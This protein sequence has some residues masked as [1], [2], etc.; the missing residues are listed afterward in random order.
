MQWV[1]AIGR[2]GTALALGLVVACGDNLRVTADASVDAPST[3][4]CTPT[5]GTDLGVQL[6][7]QMSGTI[8]LVT[9]PP[10]DRD[11][12]FAVIEDGR[13]LVIDRGPTLDDRGSVLAAPFLDISE[14][15]GDLP[16]L[17]YN[18]SE[19]GLLGLA[20]HPQYATNGQLYIAYTAYRG[21]DPTGPFFDVVM[22][23]TV[24][25]TDPDRVDPASAQLVLSIPDFAANHN[26]GMLAFGPDGYLYVATGDG[27]G[28]NDPDENG[29][30]DFSLL[31]KMLRIDVDRTSGGRAYAI[32]D[33]N[34]F[35]DGVAGAQEVYMTG[36]RN[37]WRFS[38][39]G[40]DLWIGDVGQEE[41]EE[42]DFVPATIAR[43]ANLGWKPYEGSTCLWP[44]CE[45]AGKLM[46]V[47]ERTHDE[48]WCAVIGGAV[49]RGE[50]FPDLVGDYIF[51][52]NCLSSVSR[53]RRTG[54]TFAVTDYEAPFFNPA[55]I[56]PVDGE[57]YGGDGW[58]NVFR[59]V[60]RPFARRATSNTTPSDTARISQ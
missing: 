16:F 46:P 36:L 28:A 43:G 33:D 39:D 6:V 24:S 25:A 38:F 7:A 14:L 32:P 50:C 44:P 56:Y 57:L 52:D 31:G 42:I 41:I 9:A 18:M 13:I 54:S 8:V 53:A 1:T 26:G 40:A 15:A 22:R 10:G 2:I 49:Y 37:P 35:A 11:R 55:S 51:A 29:Q 47:I 23:Y 17:G 45:P 58:G 34:P 3:G 5:P 21:T 4:R 20:F 19:L 60:V 27:G 12:L 30:D 48:G 59:I